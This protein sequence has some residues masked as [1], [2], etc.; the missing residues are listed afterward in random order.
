MALSVALMF[1]L[2]KNDPPKD[3]EPPDAN[4]EFDSE[5]T[6][7]AIAEAL[8]QAGHRV[9]LIEANEDAYQ[10]LRETRPDI[11]FNI[12]EGYRGSARESHVPAILEMLG[13]PYTG[14]NVLTLAVALDKPSAKKIWAFHGIPTPRFRVFEPGQL[15]TA[16]GLRFPLFVKP[17]RE[18]S[19][20][21][22]SPESK[23]HNLKEL[24]ERV[25]HVHRWYRQGALVEEFLEGREFT[26]GILGNQNAILLPIREVR[27]DV[28]PAEHGSVYSYHYKQVWDSDEFFYCP[29]PVDEALAQRLRA[30]ALAAFRALDSYDV[31]RVDLRLDAA[32][33]PHVLEINPLPGLAPGYSDLCKSAEAAGMS[34][35]QLVNSILDAALERYGLL[36]KDAAM[37]QTA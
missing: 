17:A 10:Q 21:G 8:A 26:I 32:G 33:V 9:L 30:T 29:A 25:A 23:V 24:R 12:A 2:G 34:Y 6:V 22:V 7:L 28:I 13:I 15:V 19:S 5:K 4:A 11:V 1:N 14:S 20:K 36:P 31:G 3:D 27:Y 16:K 37:P 35:Y 18:G